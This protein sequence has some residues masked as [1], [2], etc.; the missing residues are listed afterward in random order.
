M[1]FVRWVSLWPLGLLHAAGG[2]LGWLVWLLSPTYRRRL[3]ANADLARV[4]ARARRRSIAEAGRMVAETPWLW[5]RADADAL[6]RL[7]A[8]R[9]TGE[10][11][12]AIAGRRAVVI[13]TPHMGS[14]EMAARAYV[15]RYGAR[16]PLT[17]LYRP[18]RQRALRR[19]QESARQRPMMATAP[20]NLAGVR[21]MLRALKRRESVGLLP[22]QVPPDGQGVWAPFFGPPAYTMTLAA[23]LAQQTGAELFVLRCERLAR[24]GGYV[25]HVSRLIRELPAGSGP[26]AQAEAAAVVNATMEKVIREDPGQYMWGYN[27]YKNPRPREGDE[28]AGGGEGNA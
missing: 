11:D 28:A 18:A 24:G 7:V 13:L 1:F 16:Q 14:F 17:V 2:A 12:A 27:R 22:D 5:L 15:T 8:W 23:R 10:L 19:F 9:D 3:R 20:A 26:A 6:A 4:A 25:I 21:Q